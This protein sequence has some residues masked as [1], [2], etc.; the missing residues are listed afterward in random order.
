M[1]KY[2]YDIATIEARV[3][4][5][6]ITNVFSRNLVIQLSVNQKRSYTSLW[7]LGLIMLVLPAMLCDRFKKTGGSPFPLSKK[8]EVELVLHIS[9]KNW[10]P[11]DGMVCLN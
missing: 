10:T 1:Y 7:L 11:L 6:L 3:V 8:S 5:P 9:R 4:N 2:T